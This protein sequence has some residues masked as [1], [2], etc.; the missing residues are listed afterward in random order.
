MVHKVPKQEEGLQLRSGQSS[1]AAQLIFKKLRF[2]NDAPEDLRDGNLDVFEL[3]SRELT[4]AG[5]PP[6]VGSALCR[7]EVS[8][9]MCVSLP[10]RLKCSEYFFVK[11]LSV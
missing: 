2:C 4:A 1:S 8:C 9:S 6:G 10:Q 11:C 3:V 7:T 5:G